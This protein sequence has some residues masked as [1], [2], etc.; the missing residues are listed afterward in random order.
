MGYLKSD[1]H[2][3]RLITL[4]VM[5]TLS[6]FHWSSEKFIFIKGKTVYLFRY[7]ME[8]SQTCVQRAPSGP[9]NSG[10]CWQ[11]VVLQRSFMLWKFKMG[12]QESG[13]YR[14]VVVSSGLTVH[15]IETW[16][17]QRCQVDQE[18]GICHSSKTVLSDQIRVR[19]LLYGQFTNRFNAVKKTL[20]VS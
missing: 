19:D 8:Y 11:V 16:N 1:D 3:K 14:Q 7:K 10:R 20:T 12:P 15:E 9:K 17:V 13:R 5:I 18:F 2:N 4:S 6:A